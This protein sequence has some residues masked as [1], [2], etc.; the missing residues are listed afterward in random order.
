MLLVDRMP[1]F[2]VPTARQRLAR[3]KALGDPIPL[4]YRSSAGRETY[5]N[6]EVRD[7]TRLAQK[8]QL[9]KLSGLDMTAL[10]VAVKLVQA[11]SGRY[12]NGQPAHASRGI[13]I[14][15]SDPKVLA[16][17][18]H[19]VKHMAESLGRI[20]AS[21]ITSLKERRIHLTIVSL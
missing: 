8:N 17:F 7:K 19:R 5:V 15:S 12:A 9:E 10:G 18:V 14:R 13:P 2:P 16:H 11:A 4:G 20:D 3:A 6:P 21:F 1:R